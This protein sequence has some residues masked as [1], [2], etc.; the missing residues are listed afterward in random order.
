[1][2][3]HSSMVELSEGKIDLAD[4]RRIEGTRK[5][6]KATSKMQ[7]SFTGHAQSSNH[8]KVA[9]LTVGVHETVAFPR[10]GGAT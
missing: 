4:M 5:N 1:M 9:Q 7:H 3:L 8:L 2:V 10:L 6:L